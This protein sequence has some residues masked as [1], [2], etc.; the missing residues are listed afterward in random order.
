MQVQKSVV[1]WPMRFYTAQTISIFTL[2]INSRVLYSYVEQNAL[3]WNETSFPPTI[4]VITQLDRL[5]ASKFGSF[6]S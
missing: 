3:K 4:L 6:N 1:G 5:L 2:A